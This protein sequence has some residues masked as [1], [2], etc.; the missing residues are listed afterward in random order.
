MLVE[1]SFSAAFARALRGEPFSVVGLHELA[2]QGCRFVGG[3]AACDPDDDFVLD[4]LAGGAASTTSAGSFGVQV[5]LVGEEA[6]S[7]N[8]FRPQ[9]PGS[10]AS[11]G[12]VRMRLTAWSTS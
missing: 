7:G 1:H 3:H 4:D 12:N 11:S 10:S 2:D 5:W 6:F 8:S 9:S